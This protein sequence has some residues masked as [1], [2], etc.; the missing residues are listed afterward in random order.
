MQTIHYYETGS[1]FIHPD[2]DE[3]R[4]KLAVQQDSEQETENEHIDDKKSTRPTLSRVQLALGPLLEHL[5]TET[6]VGDPLKDHESAELPAIPADLIS[7]EDCDCL[8]AAKKLIDEGYRPAVLNMAN[9]FC[10]GGG[11]LGGDGAQEENLCRRS[12]LYKALTLD[13]FHPIDEAG[14][15]YTTNVLVFRD[16]EASGYKLL[17][18]PYFV[19]IISADAPVQPPLRQTNE[20]IFTTKE[21][22]EIFINKIK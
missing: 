6:I 8:F 2:D 19:D 10:P 5:K 20:G 18:D 7:V 3:I 13:R 17:R 9:R 15:L 16:T 4:E 21:V 1:Y 12:F 22:A 14:C 11:F